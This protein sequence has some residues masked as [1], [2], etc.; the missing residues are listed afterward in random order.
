MVECAAD[1]ERFLAEMPPL[2][3]TRFGIGQGVRLTAR[4]VMVEAASPL[5][6]LST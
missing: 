4:R 1:G 5:R 3:A 6:A 2:E